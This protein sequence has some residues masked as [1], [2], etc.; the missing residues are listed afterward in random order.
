MLDLLLYEKRRKNADFFKKRKR[1]FP[2]NYGKKHYNE[3]KK[4]VFFATCC[5]LVVHMAGGNFGI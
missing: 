3:R 1:I 4:V 5:R 2:L